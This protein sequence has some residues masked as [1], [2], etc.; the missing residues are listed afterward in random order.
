MFRFEAGFFNGAVLK[1]AVDTFDTIKRELPEDVR[2]V[3]VCQNC[4]SREGNCD[5]AVI[6]ELK[7]EASLDRY[8]KHPIHVELVKRWVPHIEVRASFDNI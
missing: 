3:E 2:A 8:L 4:V 1:D 7:E 6:L 5:L